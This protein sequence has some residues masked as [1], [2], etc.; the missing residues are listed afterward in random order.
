MA[1]AVAA[2][3]ALALQSFLGGVLSV[4][5]TGPDHQICAGIS[6]TD[7]GGPAKPLPAH[8]GCDCCTA[9]HVH[10]ASHIPVLAVSTIAWPRRHAVSLTWRPE[11]VAVPRAPPRF[12]AHAR[13]PPVV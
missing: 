7:E 10:P 3:Y 6:G 13:A 12:Q 9:A 2:L 1:I 5:L 8:A 4:S 11:V